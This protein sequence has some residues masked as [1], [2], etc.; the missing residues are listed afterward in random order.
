[1]ATMAR[2]GSSDPCSER[3]YWKKFASLFSF[4][5]DDCVMH[6]EATNIHAAIEVTPL[7]VS[8]IDGGHIRV[9]RVLAINN[10]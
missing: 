10:Y 1:M 8:G 6:A 9:Y 4:Q 2:A 3:S 7:M 5:P